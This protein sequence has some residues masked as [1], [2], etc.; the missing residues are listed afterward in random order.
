MPCLV[1]S[2]NPATLNL[3]PRLSFRGFLMVG[4]KD[5]QRRFAK[6]VCWALAASSRS[7]LMLCKSGAKGYPGEM[8][9]QLGQE[10]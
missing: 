5:K 6:A 8:L 1:G 7:V 9:L 3:M 4:V 10:P 2:D